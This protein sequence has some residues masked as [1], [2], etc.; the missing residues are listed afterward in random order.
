MCGSEISARPPGQGQLLE[1][2]QQVRQ[3]QTVVDGPLPSPC[4]GVCQLDGARAYCVGC[5]RTLDEITRWRDLAEAE[6]RAVWQRI[7]D[8]LA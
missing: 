1:R 6:Q 3:Q 5:W 8:Q 7:E 4:V 2:A